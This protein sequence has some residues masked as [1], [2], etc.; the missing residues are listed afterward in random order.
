MSP[1][2]SFLISD[3]QQCVQAQDEDF[4]YRVQSNK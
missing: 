2:F 4:F 3:E 1:Q